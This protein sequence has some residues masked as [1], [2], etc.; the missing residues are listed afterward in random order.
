MRF[1][2]PTDGSAQALAALR[3][4][5]EFARNL[6]A[7]SEFELLTVY[8]PLSPFLLMGELGMDDVDALL[9]RRSRDE[10][11]PAIDVLRRA[12]VTYGTTVIKGPVVKSILEYIR[13]EQPDLVV[14][15]VKGRGI[16][17][18]LLMGSVARAVS[19][20]SV[21]PVLLVDPRKLGLPTESPAS[22]VVP[23]Q[24]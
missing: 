7:P 22:T 15:G 23:V 17:G 3:Y 12:G 13:T 16:V 14:M 8:D 4:A 11:T 18:D 5:V 6:T 9:E 21:K 10:L 19:A 1:L 2:L 24:G 20:E